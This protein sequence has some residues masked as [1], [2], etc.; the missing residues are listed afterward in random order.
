MEKLIEA[1]PKLKDKLVRFLEK[2]KAGSFYIST[3]KRS[4][5]ISRPTLNKLREMYLKDKEG[6][7]LPLIPILAGIAAA[8]SVAGGAAGIAS[9]VNKKRAEDEALKEQQ[10]HNISLENA[11]RGKGLKEDVVGFIQANE[12]D[13][14]VKRIVKKT[15]KGLA[16]AIPIRK[17]GSSLI[18][19]PYKRGNSLTIWK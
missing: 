6:G 5:Y 16:T 10:R 11:A 3:I 15:L 4:I 7:F 1:D 9:A 14:D 8:G 17:E 18:L 19:Q 13:D 2:N 12:L